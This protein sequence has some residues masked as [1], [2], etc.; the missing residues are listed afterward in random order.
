MRTLYNIACAPNTVLID[1]RVSVGK[2][3]KLRYLLVLYLTTPLSDEVALA[4]YISSTWAASLCFSTCLL[5]Y[6]V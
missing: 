1:M 6:V 5:S 2:H 3:K 4:R